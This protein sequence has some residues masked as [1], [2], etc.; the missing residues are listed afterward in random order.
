MTHYLANGAVH[1]YSA[2]TSEWAS[3]PVSATANTGS[4]AKCGRRQW[5]RAVAA[6]TDRQP[7][8]PHGFGSV[9]RNQLLVGD[10]GLRSSETFG[11]PYFWL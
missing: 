3:L 8:G 11:M 6:G 7:I 9:L 4:E 1:V 5:W 2:F 10:G